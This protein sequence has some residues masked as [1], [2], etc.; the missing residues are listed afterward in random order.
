MAA[1]S[2]YDTA[3]ELADIGSDGVAVDNNSIST[4]AE[5]A[6]TA[7]AAG[8]TTSKWRAREKT[9]ALRFARLC[10][11]GWDRRAHRLYPKA[12]RERVVVVL[13]ICQR[14][15]LRRAAAQATEAAA[16]AAAA[17]AAARSAVAVEAEAVET[18]TETEAAAV[19]A[20][21]GENADEQTTIVAQK[22]ARAPLGVL[23]SEIWH[24]VLHFVLRRHILPS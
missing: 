3:S 16:E 7:A 6:V 2:G 15:N 24:H 11:R 20:G 23:P 1:Y 9:S 18:K 17:K 13:L 10:L 4:E 14:H 22:E 21:G 12:Y 5:F 19:T 8:L